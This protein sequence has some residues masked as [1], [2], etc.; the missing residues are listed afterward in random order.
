MS[1]KFISSINQHIINQGYSGY[2]ELYRKI[3]NVSSKDYYETYDCYEFENFDIFN[4][5]IDF[6]SFNNPYMNVDIKPSLIQG[7]GVFATKFIPKGNQINYFSG[8]SMTYKDFKEKYG[9]DWRFTYKSMPW[10]PIIQCKDDRN[11]ISFVNDGH[12]KQDIPKHNCILKKRWLVSDI[13]ILE[14]EELLLKYHDSYW[15]NH[16]PVITKKHLKFRLD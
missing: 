1:Q 10:L 7:F 11:V 3:I 6:Y 5:F 13:D 12:Y 15:K 14:G 8:K 9:N 16:K 2:N 4:G